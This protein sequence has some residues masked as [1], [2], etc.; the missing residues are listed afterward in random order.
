MSCLIIDS[1]LHTASLSIPGQYSE[2]D[3]KKLVKEIAKF[4]LLQLGESWIQTSDDMQETIMIWVTYVQA[5]VWEE[6]HFTVSFQD[7]SLL[8]FLFFDEEEVSVDPIVIQKGTHRVMVA[9]F[10]SLHEDVAN[11]IVAF[12]PFHNRETGLQITR[13][14]RRGLDL[15]SLH[16]IVEL[17]DG[18]ISGNGKYIAFVSSRW[19]QER[20]EFA[21]ELNLF[22]VQ[23][24]ESGL[25]SILSLPQPNPRMLRFSK[26]GRHL[27]FLRSTNDG[28]SD[29]IV[30]LSIHTG[31][32][33]TLVSDLTNAGSITWSID[34]SGIFF[35]CEDGELSPEGVK[36]LYITSIPERWPWWRKRRLI[37]FVTFHESTAV[38]ELV[39]KITE[40]MHETAHL[41]VTPN[42]KTLAF[43]EERCDDNVKTS[44]FLHLLDLSGSHEDQVLP[45]PNHFVSTPVFSP[46]GRFLAFVGGRVKEL[47]GMNVSLDSFHHAAQTAG[48]GVNAYDTRVF[49]VD[50]YNHSIRQLAIDAPFS[51]GIPVGMAPLTQEIHWENEDQISY[52]ATW[53]NQTILARQKIALD[54]SLTWAPL[55]T[56]SSRG[57][58]FTLDGTC[59]FFQSEM[60]E[61][62]IPALFE[63]GRLKMFPAAID[64]LLHPH[65]FWHKPEIVQHVS[66][67]GAWI[68]LPHGAINASPEEIPLIV[69]LYGGASPLCMAFEDSHQTLA[70]R[71]YA[72]LV[73]NPSGCGGFGYE[74]ADLH[75]N[76]WGE[77]V[78]DEVLD[79][80]RSVLQ[81]YPV[82]NPRA[83]GVYGGSYGGFLVMRL[84]ARSNFFQ[85]GCSIAGISNITSYWGGSYF[86]YQYG[87]SALSDSYPWTRPD[88]FIQR[89]PVFEAELM[90]TPLLLLHGEY[91]TNVPLNESEQ[92]FTALKSLGKEVSIVVFPEE[93]HGMRSSPSSRLASREYLVAWFDKH[94]QGIEYAWK[95]LTAGDVEQG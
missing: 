89:S 8:G 91:D 17:T 28:S 10:S 38:T 1:W 24:E 25:Q 37:Q 64:N 74:S 22:S 55:G 49:V 80:I 65:L 90:N 40:H 29:E 57:H 81:Q 56:G 83:V 79:S 82:L 39:F 84:L 85:A 46:S 18:V 14:P 42:G 36:A 73:L 58:S 61:P 41:C 53:G 52:I 6:G 45:L 34:M 12:H 51:A 3:A 71:G 31:R 70:T 54:S 76:D 68:Y 78:L 19:N 50:T 47:S 72:V 67:K 9:A 69:Y 26:D 32:M 95:Q 77:I 11:P 23:D 87:R 4:D 48:N 62:F 92:I 30:V 7:N 63:S 59:F 44:L 66:V 27:A 93:D 20:D 33:K 43:V 2:N 21:K 5:S 13:D 16:R 15:D 86:G 35:V 75:V 94:L 60:G 88:I